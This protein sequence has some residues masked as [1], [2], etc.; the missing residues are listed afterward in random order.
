MGHL[1]RT[2]TFPLLHLRLAG[3]S[4]VHGDAVG[5]C[6]DDDDDETAV[7][8]DAEALA[9]EGPDEDIP[10]VDEA[11]KTLD[12]F[13]DELSGVEEDPLEEESLEQQEPG[14][15]EAPGRRV[16]RSLGRGELEPTAEDLSQDPTLPIGSRVHNGTEFGPRRTAASS[17]RRIR[18]R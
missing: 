8:A 3:G 16:T 5:R 10:A 12:G 13:D 7:A 2:P 6:G 17:T 1:R 18:E 9:V 4:I 15:A 11:N 14:A